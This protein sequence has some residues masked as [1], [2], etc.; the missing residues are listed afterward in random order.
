MTDGRDA[1]HGAQHGGSASVVMKPPTVLPRRA[2]G[3]Y[4]RQPLELFEPTL[5]ESV[6]SESLR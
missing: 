2:L 6:G 5:P 4:I 3:T 1:R